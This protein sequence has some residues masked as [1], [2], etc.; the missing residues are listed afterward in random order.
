M[1]RPR[2]ISFSVCPYV[3]RAV[4]ALEEKGVEYDVEFIDLANKPQWFL[5]I[6]PRGKVP[7]LIDGDV[8]LFE[9][10]AIVEFL[11]ETQGGRRLAPEDAR[12]RARDRAWATYASEEIFTGSW[13]LE[14]AKDE[15]S[16]VAA[17]DA[18]KKKLGIVNDALAN[19]AFLSGD[20]S[21]FGLA[22]IAFAPALYRLARWTELGVVDGFFDGLDHVA[23]W[24]Q[25]ML[26]QGS[27]M[28]SVPEGW[29]ADLSTLAGRLHSHIAA[30]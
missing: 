29:A 1:N 25:R 22:D 12:E 17:R 24:S 16:F 9:S 5:D 3:Q 6:S 13:S 4:I 26:S 20:G 23:A 11:D 19:R 21:T 8:P 2:L 14:S 7:V 10:Q 30:G 18:L 27:V 28:R 15:D